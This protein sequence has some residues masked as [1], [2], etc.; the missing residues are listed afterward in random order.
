VTGAGP[1]PGASGR[2]ATARSATAATASKTRASGTFGAIR[3]FMALL[4]GYR[5]RLPQSYLGS[6]AGARHLRRRDQRRRADGP[7]LPGRIAAA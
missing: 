5:R 4:L 6:W 2:L 1:V 7:V 3:F